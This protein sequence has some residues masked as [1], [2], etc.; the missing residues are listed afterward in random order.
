MVSE[1]SLRE[2][3]CSSKVGTFTATETVENACTGVVDPSKFPQTTSTFVGD[4]QYFINNYKLVITAGT[5]K[6]N[7]SAA[8]TPTS[9]GAQSTVALVSS[10]TA[11]SSGVAEATGAAAPMLSMAPVLAGLGAAVAFLV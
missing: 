5:E 6:L 9:S 4:E 2:S 8:A 11:G 7:A 1:N 3:L 10:G